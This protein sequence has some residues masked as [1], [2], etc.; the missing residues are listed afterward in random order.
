VDA[1]GWQPA[2]RV[3]QRL[4]EALQTGDHRRFATTLQ[5]ARL[6]VPQLPELDDHTRIALAALL[7]TPQPHLLA[8][9][10]PQL[11]TEVVGGLARSYEEVRFDTLRQRWPDPRIPL[12][13]NPGSPIAVFLPLSAVAELATGE[14]TLASIAEMAEALAEQALVEIRRQCLRDLAAGQAADVDGALRDDPPTNTL[15][16]TLRAAAQAGDGEEFLGRLLE[17][18]VVLPTT[19]PVP[20]PPDLA[21]PE[22]PWRLTGGQTA[23]A[24]PMFSS[25]TQLAR[26]AGPAASAVEVPFL[27]VVAH[28][29]EGSPAL[30]FNPGTVTEL[31][32]SEGELMTLMTELAAAVTGPEPDRQ[33]LDT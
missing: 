32:L 29:P 21:D 23:P 25:A 31:I 22:F 19:A 11:L 18:T 4:A 1:S 24:V 16:E 9:T 6:Y 14:R 28:W 27:S 3:E 20:D 8:F 7:P 15:E 10:S 5:S 33:E 30:C 2:N 17:A 12:A 13:L 26:V